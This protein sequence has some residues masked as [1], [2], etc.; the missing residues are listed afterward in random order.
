[1][2]KPD[3]T[4]READGSSPRNNAE[5]TRGV[6]FARGNPGRRKGS[7]NKT[8][9]AVEALI[10]GQHAALT[11]KLIAK[12]LEG[13][14]T[15]LKLCLDRLAPVRRDAPVCIDLPEV[16]DARGLVAASAAVLAEMAK[17]DIT[18][19]E[20]ASIMATLSA[21]K[22]LIET[23]DLEVRLKEVEKRMQAQK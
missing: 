15:A 6:P 8:T 20:A 5:N 1:M 7:R 4:A 16:K 9:I 12:A 11:A 19:P 2:L 23:F 18:P 3:T 22:Q 21:H 10:E 14:M 13:D 17:G